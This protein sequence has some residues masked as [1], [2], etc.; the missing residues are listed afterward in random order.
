MSLRGASAIVVAVSMVASATLAGA[1]DQPVSGR[2]LCLRASAIDAERRHLRFISNDPA[3]QAPFADPASGSTLIVRSSAAPGQCFAEIPL[4]PSRWAPL[5]GDG[6]THGYV[7]TAPAPGTQGV[8][9]IRLRQGKIS[10][11]ARGAAFPC[12]LT[13]AT[14]SVPV[15]V[16]LRIGTDRYCS[17]FGGSV[18]RNRPG[19]FRALGA[20]AP[21]TCPDTD[22]TVANLN[23]L[24]G[25]PCPD[26]A[27]CRLPDRLALLFQFIADRG[28]PDVVTLQE[29]PDISPTF[30]ALPLVDALRV[31][32]CPFPYSR[33]FFRALGIDEEMILSR[34]PVL[35]AQSQPLHGAFRHITSAR[36]DHPIGP[37]DVYTTHLASSSDN[38]PNPCFNCPPEC[39][40]AGAITNRDC[41]AVQLAAFAENTHDV[42]A[43]ALITGDFNDAPGSFV[44]SELVSRGWPDTYLDVGNPECV[45][46]TGIGCTSGRA[47]AL[48]ELEATA[49]NV[50]ERIDFIFMVPPG[51]A[52]ACA[53]SIDSPLDGDGDGT[54]TRLFADEPNPFAPSCGPLP[55]PICWSS[56]HSGVQ[57][58]INCR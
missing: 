4:D 54:A 24:H 33:V 1:V 50:D 30:T 39:L 21:A 42:A 44:Y 46:A 8:R 22:V 13:A 14:Q 38:G 47:D 53:G 19:R 11:S 40:L 52:S 32:T 43:P 56:D 17:A 28:C 34:Y 2:R 29:V 7:Y 36:I 49:L 23:I 45:P 31:S 15:T 26:P 48:S 12:A 16:E 18:E 20:A 3:I 51:V 41:Q 10:I 9:S 57:A 55:D 5:R 37:V 35:T 58:D 27:H 25:L 6:I